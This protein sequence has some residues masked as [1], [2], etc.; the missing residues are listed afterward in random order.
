MTGKNY[1]TDFLELQLRLGQPSCTF[2]NSKSETFIKIIIISNPQGDTDIH[3]HLSH[4]IS[5]GQVSR[6]VLHEVHIE[7]PLFGC[8]SLN[9]LD[10]RN[11]FQVP[12]KTQEESLVQLFFI[13]MSESHLLRL[14]EE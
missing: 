8:S 12:N 11:L 4:L 13:L 5:V 14:R 2:F 3:T 9:L 7:Q 6:F 1:L 10:L